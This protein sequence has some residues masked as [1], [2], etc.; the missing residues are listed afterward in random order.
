[1]LSLAIIVF[2]EV[3]EIALI[4]GV[5][6]VATRGLPGRNRWVW[7]GLGAGVVG[8]GLVAIMADAIS[9]AISG[10]GQE[11]FNASVLMLAA[12]LIGWTVVWMKRHSQVL[13]Q[14][15]KQVGK[16]VTE[17]RQPRYVIAVVVALAVLREGSEI[18][19][20]TYGVM[21]SG[22]TIAQLVFGG[23]AGLALGAA[24]GAA[25]YLGIVRVAAK[26]AFTVTSVLLTFLAAG[27]VS[28]A[29]QLLDQAGFIP[30]LVSPL[31]DTSHILSERSLIGGVLHT[32]VG[33]TA[34]PTAIQ[35][36]VYVLTILTIG[37]LIKLYG[38][39]SRRSMKGTT[40]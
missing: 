35:T 15:L 29:V 7:V 1:M 10:M 23:L 2:R 25:I 8:S 36:T 4:L 31:W 39:G 27:M 30:V 18:V 24:M 26:Y 34:Q 40:T 11:V 28:Q 19:L 6:L 3:L 21:I 14:R 16:A 32:L 33:Y 13:A 9:E 12:L 37:M 20:L 38:G 17:G 22:G 5:V